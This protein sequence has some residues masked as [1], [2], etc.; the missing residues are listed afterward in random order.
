VNGDFKNTYLVNFD[1]YFNH[2]TGSENLEKLDAFTLTNDDKYAYSAYFDLSAGR[3][4]LCKISAQTVVEYPD[5]LFTNNSK[6]CI[7]GRI[8]NMNSYTVINGGGGTKELLVIL[9][10]KV[11]NGGIAPMIVVLDI[12]GESPAAVMSEPVMIDMTHYDK[13]AK[14]TKDGDTV[15]YEVGRFDDT[16]TAY[17][18]TTDKGLRIDGKLYK[19]DNGKLIEDTYP[20]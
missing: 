10:D 9:A 16:I 15:I 17:L 11:T 18:Q 4:V 5:K 2:K 12:S 8:Y 13:N 19:I 1:D 6:M 14:T 7:T 20:V 3:S